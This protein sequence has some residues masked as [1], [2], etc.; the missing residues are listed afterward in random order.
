MVDFKKVCFSFL[1]DF[2]WHGLFAGNVSHNPRPP[3]AMVFG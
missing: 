3:Y 1:Y 2:L